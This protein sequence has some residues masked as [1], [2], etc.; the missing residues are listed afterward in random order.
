MSRMIISTLP[1]SS[2]Y[3]AA[4]LDTRGT[5]HTNGRSPTLT[6]HMPQRDLTELLGRW[7]AGHVPAREEPGE[8]VQ[9]HHRLRPN[10]LAVLEDALPYMRSRNAE[11]AA[12]I[13][14][15]HHAHA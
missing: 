11:V 4:M 3:A 7:H 15:K 6:L 10:V 2:E 9:R 8:D 13:L 14:G 5:I 12:R 1:I